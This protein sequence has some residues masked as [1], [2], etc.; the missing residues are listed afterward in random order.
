MTTF[1]EAFGVTKIEAPF[2]VRKRIR[3]KKAQ[4][5]WPSRQPKP[6][7]KREQ[8]SNKPSPKKKASKKPKK[9][10]FSVINVGR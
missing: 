4:T 1:C 3:K 10:P 8:A 7:I 2:A 5:K 6:F 9:D